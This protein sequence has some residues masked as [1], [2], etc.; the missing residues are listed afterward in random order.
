[1]A[2]MTQQLDT[3]NENDTDFSNS[4]DSQGPLNSMYCMSPE[5]GR[6][7]PHANDT[8]AARATQQC[9]LPSRRNSLSTT[10]LSNA[11]SRVQSRRNSGVERD[12]VGDGMI[13]GPGLIGGED[14]VYYLSGKSVVDMLAVA[15]A[16]SGLSRSSSYRYRI[17]QDTPQCLTD[18]DPTQQGIEGEV[19]G[20]DRSDALLAQARA[21][22][23]WADILH[24]AQSQVTSSLRS[25][26][27]RPPR[28]PRSPLEMAGSTPRGSCVGGQLREQQGG[29]HAAIG[30]T[31]TTAGEK[32]AGCVLLS[33]KKGSQVCDC[34]N[35]RARDSV[36]Y[37]SL[38]THIEFA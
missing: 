30:S 32:T 38:Q 9:L 4:P 13:S 33:E 31:H 11:E 26:R 14:K 22:R 6:H 8:V 10:F 36:P 18:D 17:G 37:S 21:I 34:V 1:M 29:S 16:E 5:H 24:Q 2:S 3:V 28:T 25:P 19:D 15:A 20:T 12:L 7:P 35:V 23:E 27:P